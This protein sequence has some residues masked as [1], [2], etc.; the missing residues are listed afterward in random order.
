MG[1]QASGDQ[2]LPP[3]AELFREGRATGRITSPVRSPRFGSIAIGMIRREVEAGA[4]LA[5]SSSAKPDVKVKN[6][7]F[8][9]S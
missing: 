2:T 1:L 8:T 3:A 6:L 9:S 4:F 7:P 5:V